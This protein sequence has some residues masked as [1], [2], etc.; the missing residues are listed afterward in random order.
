MFSRRC[1]CLY[2]RRSQFLHVF[3]KVV[4]LLVSSQKYRGFM[5]L[6]WVVERCPQFLQRRSLNK[7][8][9]VSR[10][11]SAIRGPALSLL[12]PVEASFMQGSWLMVKLTI[13]F[14]FECTH[15][16]NGVPIETVLTQLVLEQLLCYLLS[17]VEFSFSH[18]A[19][20][21]LTHSCRIHRAVNESPYQARALC[22]TLY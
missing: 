21:W 11:Y 14:L 10:E 18:G 7:F 8:L 22:R 15:C 3:V 2:L 13:V 19:V 6:L 1:P 12:F 5:I 16:D 17:K 4:R 20:L 9:T